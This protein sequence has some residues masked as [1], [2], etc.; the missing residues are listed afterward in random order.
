MFF[1]NEIEMELR[2]S[3][4]TRKCGRCGVKSKGVIRS[5]CCVTY[6]CQLCLLEIVTSSKACISCQKSFS[7]EIVVPLALALQ[8]NFLTTKH[9]LELKRMEFSF[10]AQTLTL[11][12]LVFV[13][14]EIILPYFGVF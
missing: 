12:G 5:S 9:K 14:R 3:T 2:V 11:I 6:F 10:K 13:L 4:R 7:V 1:S 8:K